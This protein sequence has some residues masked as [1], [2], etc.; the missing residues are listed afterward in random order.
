MPRVAIVLGSKSDIP[1]IEGCFFVLDQA[2]EKYSL[3]ILSAHRAPDKVRKFAKEAE[4]KGY[5]VI[6]AAAGGAAALPG[7]IAAY[8]SL[9]V[10]GIPVKTTVFKGIDSLLSIVQMPKGVPVATMPVG[11]AGGPNAA[12]LALRILAQ[13]PKEK[14]RR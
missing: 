7:V 14:C 12:L 10:I 8:T 6:I 4:S 13:I 11:K 1:K 2:K 5:K 3:Y 9:P